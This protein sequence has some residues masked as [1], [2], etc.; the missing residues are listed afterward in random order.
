MWTVLMLKSSV[1]QENH[2]ELW[3][4]TEK[5]SKQEWELRRGFAESDG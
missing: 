1:L 4:D 2:S 5:K 3:Q